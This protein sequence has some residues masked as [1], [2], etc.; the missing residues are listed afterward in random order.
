MCPLHTG[1]YIA[2]RGT[3]LREP[4]AGNDVHVEAIR[5]ARPELEV[6]AGG[7]HGGVIGA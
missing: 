3:V 2:L 7:N 4:E 1:L 6:T 5:P